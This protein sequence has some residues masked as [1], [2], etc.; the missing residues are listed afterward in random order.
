MDGRM[1]LTLLNP[2]SVRDTQALPVLLAGCKL[3]CPLLE[4]QFLHITYMDFF[5]VRVCSPSSR[6]P[7]GY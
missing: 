3:H 6:L 1:N 7:N 5:C 2:Q 4:L